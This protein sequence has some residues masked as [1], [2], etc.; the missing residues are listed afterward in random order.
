MTAPFFRYCPSPHH[1]ARPQGVEIDL[2]VVHAISLPPGVFGGPAIEALFMGRLDPRAHPSFQ[3]ISNLRVSA[4]FVIDRQGGVTQYVPVRQ[5]AWHAGVSRWEGREGCNDFSIGIEVE[6]DART[7][8]ETSQYAT[9]AR[10]IALLQTRYPVLKGDRIVGHEHIAPGRKWDPGP[11]FDWSRLR[12]LL[13]G[14]GD[15][16]PV[17]DWPLIWET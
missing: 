3:E 17:H 14:P 10:L 2:V 11:L 12:G 1:N 6:G 5:R 7:P 8:F 9:L 13:D 15:V 16:V 4:H